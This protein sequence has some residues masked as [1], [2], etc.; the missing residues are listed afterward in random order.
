MLNRLI[1]SVLLV[2]LAMTSALAQE[3]EVV[4]RKVAVFPFTVASREP[5]EPL[6]E[7]ARQEMLE[8]LKADGFSL[9]SQEALNKELAPLKEP[10]N[11][12][13]AQ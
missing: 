6:G 8:R 2:A 13:R 11:D 4:L 7:K 3:E 9:V 10:V 12:A 5:L 1:L